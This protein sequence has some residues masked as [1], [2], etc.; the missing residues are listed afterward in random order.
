MYYKSNFSI[1]M[2]ILIVLTS[3]IQAMERERQEDR[4][5]SIELNGHTGN[6]SSAAFSPDGNLIVTVSFDNTARVWGAHTGEC[7]QILKGHTNRLSSA[8]FSP[9]GNL[10]VTASHDNTARVWDAHTGKC[11]QILEG[12]TSFVR[13]ALMVI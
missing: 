2:F 13:S 4:I 6:V 8:A 10:I 12:H 5:Q 1:L 3:C 9:D 11:K 7:K